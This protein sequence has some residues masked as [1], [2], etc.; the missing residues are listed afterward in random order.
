MR[1][2]ASRG[3]WRGPPAGR[4]SASTRIRT[5]PP[6][7]PAGRRRGHDRAASAPTP[8]PAG[9]PPPGPGLG[10]HDPPRPGTAGRAPGAPRPCTRPAAQVGGG[11]ALQHV[12]EQ[13]TPRR[14]ALPAIVV[15]R[16]PV[17]LGVTADE[18]DCDGQ[19]SVGSREHH[20][21]QRPGARREPDDV[22][23]QVGLAGSSQHRGAGA[24]LPAGVL[25]PQERLGG[26]GGDRLE[27]RRRPRAADPPHA[28]GDG[29][30]SAAG[31]APRPGLAGWSA[32]GRRASAPSTHR[33]RGRAARAGRSPGVGLHPAR[34]Q[35]L[36][37]REVA[38]KAGRL[39]VQPQ[40]ACPRRDAGHR[41]DEGGRR[42]GQ[43]VAVREEGRRQALLIVHPGRP[44]PERDVGASARDEGKQG[45]AADA[46][47]DT[48]S[49]RHRAV[50]RPTR[51]VPGGRHQ[52]LGAQERVGARRAGRPGPATPHADPA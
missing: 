52:E 2:P 38:G 19:H 39:L 21:A 34:G 7:L 35:R 4:A 46:L 50:G 18:V 25:E 10:G 42:G 12:R 24:A 27:R 16:L 22:T 48:V 8:R 33:H 14:H 31:R 6:R 15:R 1:Q 20:Q 5:D 40:Q 29:A 3:W 28:R 44:P 49:S 51:Q 13:Q 9:N 41:G 11:E 30:S 43:V 26:V 36:L 32:R 23:E 37:E 17:E 45:R 47:R